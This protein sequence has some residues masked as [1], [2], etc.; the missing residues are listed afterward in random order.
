MNAKRWTLAFG[1]RGLAIAR[2]LA[3]AVARNSRPSASFVDLVD[4]LRRLWII[5]AVVLASLA[6]S[7]SAWASIRTLGR[8]VPTQAQTGNGLGAIAVSGSSLAVAADATVGSNSHQGAV[9]VFTEG[10]AGW[11]SA[12]DVAE[13]TASNG[14]AGDQMGYDENELAIAGPTIVAGAFDAGSQATPAYTAPPGAVYL[15]QEPAAGWSGSGQDAAQLEPP[16][17]AGCKVTSP[18]A[19]FAT[20]A[21]IGCRAS[22]PANSVGAAFVFTKPA[23]GW[24]GQIQPSATLVPAQGQSFADIPS[25][26]F[27]GQTVFAEDGRVVY[28]FREPAGGWSGTVAASATLRAP[29]PVSEFAVSG[30]TVFSAPPASL[31]NQQAQAYVYVF[32]EPRRGWLGI[33]RPSATLLYPSAAYN[34]GPAM[35]ASGRMLTISASDTYDG[36]GPMEHGCP[37]ATALDVFRAPGDGWSGTLVPD[38]SEVIVTP[39]TLALASQ[40]QTIFASDTNEILLL[41]EQPAKPTVSTDALKGLALGRPSIGFSLRAGSGGGPPIRTVTISLPRGLAFN[42]DRRRLARGI[43]ATGGHGYALRLRGGR[44]TLA[45]KQSTS[46][47]VVSIRPTALIETSRLRARAKQTARFRPL[48]EAVRLLATDF[49]SG[50]STLTLHFRLT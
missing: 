7:S 29:N 49:N 24:T 40:S 10:A 26:A 16:P 35:A 15:F 48:E 19:V 2:A 12:T 25:L 37:C 42:T 18:V 3:L 47:T 13:L 39:G 8:L 38:S 50:Q 32:S 4:R 45:F 30:S 44:L 11:S 1:G 22:G 34:S 33:V 21:A 46:A 17:S 31:V 28:V 14:G 23:G 5:V 6:C 20:T 27:S 43:R 9:Y 36:L 41:T